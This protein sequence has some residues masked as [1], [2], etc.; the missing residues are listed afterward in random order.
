MQVI[1]EEER[2]LRAIDEIES[3]LH[4]E[5]NFMGATAELTWSRL[6]R[7]VG[8]IN[9]EGADLRADVLQSCQILWGYIEKRFLRTCHEYLWKLARG[10]V[11][12]NLV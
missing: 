1:L 7:L 4:E 5:F 2:L 11:E 10:D 12:A 9:Y 3:T 8:D 6:A